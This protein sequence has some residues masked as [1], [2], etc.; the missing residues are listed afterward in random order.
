MSLLFSS[1]PT[2]QGGDADTALTAYEI[3]VAGM[4]EEDVRAGFRLLLQGAAPGQNPSFAPPGP[5]VAALVRRI[6]DARLGEEQR[7]RSL[8]RQI[9]SRDQTVKTGTSEDRAAF[10]REQMRRF[11]VGDSEGDADAA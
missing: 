7:L 1:Y 5:F 6:R 4:P 10:V 3:A 11:A 8:Q 2:F 9:E